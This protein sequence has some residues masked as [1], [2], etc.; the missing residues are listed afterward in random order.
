M[1][2]AARLLGED[3]DVGMLAC[4]ARPTHVGLVVSSV[5]K[6]DDLT[7]DEQFEAAWRLVRAGLAE[8]TP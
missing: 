6:W 4:A 7:I 2:S 5:S 1:P 8:G 3:I